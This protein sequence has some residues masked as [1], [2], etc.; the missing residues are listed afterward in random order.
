MFTIIGCLGTVVAQADTI[1]AAIDAVRSQIPLTDK[2]VRAM[3]N[4]LPKLSGA[5]EHH[6]DYGGSGCTVR[7]A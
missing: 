3:R 2:K 1:D 6:V 5:A 4:A 7:L